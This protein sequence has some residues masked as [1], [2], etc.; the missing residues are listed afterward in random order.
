ME[1]VRRIRHVKASISR[2]EW[3][4]M[5]TKEIYYMRFG[6]RRVPWMIVKEGHDGSQ[7]VI[8]PMDQLGFHISAHPL[9]GPH[10]KDS[11]GT[12]QRLD[13]AALRSM[14]WD[15]AARQFEPS[16]ESMFYWPSHRSDLI[17]IPGPPG[18]TWVEGFQE[19]LQGNEFD[20]IAMLKSALGHG[21]IYKVG[22]RERRA[23]FETPLGKGCII[24]D[25]RERRFG[26]YA[27]GPY[28]DR[29][30][31]G[32]RWE[33]GGLRLPLPPP[34]N[35]WQQALEVR[36]ED[37]TEQYFEAANKELE[38]GMMEVLPEL[39]T[40]VKALKVIRWSPQRSS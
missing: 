33:E 8:F 22:Y 7:Y 38:A 15:E 13:V 31:F 21:T 28:P 1:I 11:R 3:T 16:W 36:L 25:S 26:F 6:S 9:A 34:V 24:I 37:A 30:L 4:K 40:F 29:P 18:K 17:A 39:E 19:L 14:N 10:M 12:V 35:E 2:L 27:T 32:M 23:F 5:P 20:V